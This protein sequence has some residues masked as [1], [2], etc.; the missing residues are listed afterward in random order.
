MGELKP[1]GMKRVR[2]MGYISSGLSFVLYWFV[3]LFG[4]V[5][6]GMKQKDSLVVD[7]QDYNRNPL[8]ICALF[9]VG[10]SVLTCFEMHIY[11]IRQFLAYAIRKSR[12]LDVDDEGSDN[13]WRGISYTRL[14]DIGS[15]IF[16]VIVC[17]LIAAKLTKIKDLTDLIGAFASRYI[18]FVVPPLCL[19]KIRHRQG[20]IFVRPFEG[21]ICILMLLLGLFFVLYG[22]YD[23][24]THF[25]WE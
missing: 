22:T 16:S 25:S 12:G 7:F 3:S 11:P 24:V 6:F 17:I 13:Q 2:G 9:A 19:M 14:L 5:T 8:V 18:A 15:A 23:A 4:V 20:G 21:I 10:F 1:Q